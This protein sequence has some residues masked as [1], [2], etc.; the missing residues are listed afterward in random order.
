MAAPY[1]DSV[2]LTTSPRLSLLQPLDSALC[3]WAASRSPSGCPPASK[4]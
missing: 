1:V 2:K 3:L 4:A